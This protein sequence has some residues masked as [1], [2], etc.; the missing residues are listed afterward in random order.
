M[1]V[2]EPKLSILIP[3]LVLPHMLQFAIVMIRW[4][5]LLLIIL[6]L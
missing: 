2:P 4:T 1:W 6:A 3:P 5:S